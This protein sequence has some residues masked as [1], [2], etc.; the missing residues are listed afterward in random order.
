[1]LGDA[2]LHLIPQALAIHNHGDHDELD[3]DVIEV[4][5]FVLKQLVVLGAIYGFY[6]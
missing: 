6:L 4:E 3:I 1:M 5:T 2:L